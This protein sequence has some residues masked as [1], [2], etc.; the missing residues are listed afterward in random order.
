MKSKAAVAKA[1]KDKGIPLPVK[2]S[3]SAMMHRLET[4][5]EGKGYLF[6]RIKSRFYGQQQLPAEIPL[7]TVV[8]VP[9]S[10]F[11]RSLIKTGAMFPM[12]RAFYDDKIH[13]LID[14]PQTEEYKEPKSAPKKKPAPK[15]KESKKVSKRGDN[16][17]ADS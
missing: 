3:Y 16:D 17:S 1:L 6:R 4:W 15:K 7:G 10:D 11:A 12:G 2:D 13:T 14:V 5:K 8:F 9:N